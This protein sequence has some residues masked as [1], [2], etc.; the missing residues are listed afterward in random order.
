M[1]N[2]NFKNQFKILI[3]IGEKY[4][5]NK[6]NEDK[7]WSNN[8]LFEIICELYELIQI[9]NGN[10]IGINLIETD[11]LIEAR[12][13]ILSEHLKEIL[14]YER[15]VHLKLLKQWGA[16]HRLVEFFL[17]LENVEI[18]YKELL[19]IFDFSKFV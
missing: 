15:R 18:N 9:I 6:I 14:N 7:K 3:N 8:E 16:K 10:E 13:L 19:G 11:K 17:G 4:I 2:D 5:F 12:M 1:G